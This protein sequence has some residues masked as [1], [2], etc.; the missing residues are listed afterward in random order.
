VD[1]GIL[2]GSLSGVLLGLAGLWALYMLG[3]L[4][5]DTLWR[6]A[7]EGFV[8]SA[9]ELG[10]TLQRKPHV[11]TGALWAGWRS[12]IDAVGTVDGW[13]V[14]LRLTGGLKGERYVLRATGP[15]GRVRGAL[16]LTDP[17]DLTGWVRGQLGGASE[18]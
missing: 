18:E 17:E 11:I 3:A 9:G 10:L 2:I 13:R 5:R 7:G 16:S 14:S 15:E 12:S 1:D 4:W 8:S 6:T